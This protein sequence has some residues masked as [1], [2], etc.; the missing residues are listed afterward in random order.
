MKKIAVAVAP[1]LA[2]S[3]LVSGCGKKQD[4]AG[5]SSSK[6]VQGTQANKLTEDQ[7][8]GALVAIKGTFGA[9]TK[10]DSGVEVTVTPPENIVPSADAQNYTDTLTVNKMT[11]TIK[12]GS[13]EDLDSSA[14]VF[15]ADS[16]VN[17]CMEIIDPANKLEGAP[18][19]IVAAGET[20]TFPYA[21]GC[22][23]K[24]GDDLVFKVW[25]SAAKVNIEGKLA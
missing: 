7:T 11:V 6:E 3:L 15:S 2:L 20:L 1:L 16:G 25:F 14:I 4:A 23:G 9:T 22:V 5:E 10:I 19:V 24:P 18:V 12:N 21:T 8:D 13:T 17:T